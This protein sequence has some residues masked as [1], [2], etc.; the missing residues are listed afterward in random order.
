MTSS[1]PD[2]RRG[3]RK[4][5]RIAAALVTAALLAVA[6][7]LWTTRLGP[8]I[9]SVS[10][11]RIFLWALLVLFGCM[12]AMYGWRRGSLWRLRRGIQ[13]ERERLIERAIEVADALLGDAVRVVGVT[14]EWA[15]RAELI[16][17]DLRDVEEYMSQLAKRPHLRQAMVAG[18]DGLV[19]AASEPQLKGQRLD[20]VLADL[21]APASDVQLS[22]GEGF[23]RAVVPVMGLES[24]LGTL[25]FDYAVTDLPARLRALASAG[26]E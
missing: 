9:D 17:D 11:R 23:L 7:Y 4:G 1:T 21:P 15:V 24:R 26:H 18:A 8:R 12:V 13:R 20:R 2:G 25:V 5:L 16:R 22:R 19:I 6:A 10:P 3:S 14:L